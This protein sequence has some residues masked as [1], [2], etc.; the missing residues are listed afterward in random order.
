GNPIGLIAIGRDI[1]ENKRNRTMLEE[2]TAEQNAILENAIV[3]IAYLKGRRFVRMNGKMEQIFGYTREEVIGLTTEV[4]YPSIESYEELGR[5]AYPIL[6]SGKAYH[7]ERLMKRKDGTCFWCSLSGK[8]VDPSSPDDG[9]IWIL[10]DI[11]KRKRAEEEIKRI[12]QNLESL[13]AERTRELKQTNERLMAEIAERKWVEEELIKAQKLESLGVLAGGIA[14]DF[15]N[16]LSIILGNTEV[17]GTVL[18]PGEEAHEQLSVVKQAAIQARGITQQLLTFAK[19]GA[20]I[21]KVVSMPQFIRECVEFSL[22]GT[23]VRAEYSLPPDLWRVEIDE[24]QINQVLN[25]L[26]INAVQAMPEGGALVVIAGNEVVSRRASAG[27]QAGRRYL[28]IE[29][30]DHGL[31]IPEK[32]LDKIF[33][34]Y[35]T[36]KES[37]SGLGLSIVYSIVKR[38]GG[39]ITVDST[40]GKGSTF[41]IFLPATDR[42]QTERPAEVEGARPSQPGRIL[43]MDDEAAVSTIAA[44]MLQRLGHQAETVQDGAEA[45]SA[46]RQ[47]LAKGEP[48]DIVITDLTVP[49]GMGGKETIRRLLEIDPQ[50]KVIVSSGYAND[51]IMSH[52][53]D[54]GFK[55]VI[56]KPYLLEELGKTIREVLGGTEEEL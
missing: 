15:N 25:N 10:Q 56:P 23:N 19:G 9:S 26:A 31:G 20:P 33:D 24:S 44:R 41:I 43:V 8:A 1:T 3:G 30:T 36:T 7:T 35:S 37:G 27:L 13:V 45:V 39:S 53:A 32:N 38:H 16:I 28:R 6:A 46:Y 54:Y 40:P 21:K 14:H 42:K 49:A 29:I 5:E 22:R 11:S 52:F 2:K 55:G 18:P 17:I 51:P 48:F 34:P 4:H 50:A 47:A 12:N